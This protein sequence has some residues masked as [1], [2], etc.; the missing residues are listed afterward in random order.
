M[1]HFGEE[2]FDDDDYEDEEEGD[3]DTSWSDL[4]ER[5]IGPEESASRSHDRL[6]RSRSHPPPP[7]R[8]PPRQQARGPY[9]TVVDPPPGPP[10]G[11][12]GARSRDRRPQRPRSMMDNLDDDGFPYGRPG[13]LP[14]H[15]AREWGGIGLGYGAGQGPASL[16]GYVDPFEVRTSAYLFYSADPFS[17]PPYRGGNPFA[18][19]D[20]FGG[21]GPR[22]P[23]PPRA[24][25]EIMAYNQGYPGYPPYGPFPPYG[26]APFGFPF[27]PGPAQARPPS[28]NKS[29]PAPKEDTEEQIR[30]KRVEEMLL[31]QRKR[32]LDK[33][34]AEAR[35]KMEQ[36]KVAEE[37]KLAALHALIL[38]HNQ[39][40]NERDKKAE[41]KA[42]KEADEKAAAAHMAAIAKKAADD[43]AAELTKAAAEKEAALKKAAEDKEA[44]LT[45]AAADKE[46]EMKKA[47]EDKEKELTEAAKKAKEELEAEAKK[48]LDESEEKRKKLEEENKLLKPPD[49][50]KQPPIKFKDAVGRKFSFPWHLCK[51]WKVCFFL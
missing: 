28:S 20:Y 29:T 32:E 42:K 4:G 3:E 39:D 48:K 21:R 15:P 9:Q 24:N 6:P 13:Q 11:R 10:P 43:K 23:M 8:D 40:Q 47:A 7:V 25:N 26:P 5:D 33:Q 44:E 35:I 12:R 50:M 14:Y 27:P 36:K 41:E 31:D 1:R 46:A 2:G 49:D 30:L 18:V 37:D 38:K 17:S 51:E 16:S 22:N 45:K 34:L 19:D